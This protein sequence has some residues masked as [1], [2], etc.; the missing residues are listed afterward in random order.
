MGKLTLTAAGDL[1]PG[2]VALMPGMTRVFVTVVETR[3]PSHALAALHGAVVVV[4]DR[5]RFLTADRERFG[6]TIRATWTVW[7]WQQVWVDNAPGT[8]T[9]SHHGTPSPREA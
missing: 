7:P 4:A 2:D 5:D 3:E 6:P 9:A 1:M 8:T